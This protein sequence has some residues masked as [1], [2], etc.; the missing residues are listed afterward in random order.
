MLKLPAMGFNSG[1]NGPVGGGLVAHQYG[2][3]HFYL[4][5]ENIIVG[6]I[7]ISSVGCTKFPVSLFRVS[8]LLVLLD[9]LLL[10][11]ALN[12]AGMTTKKAIV[13]YS[14]IK[15]NLQFVPIP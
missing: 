12:K 5:P 2:I 3:D 6:A 15:V 11:Q 7:T 13:F 10:L 8:T 9:E 14:L 4:L 1:L